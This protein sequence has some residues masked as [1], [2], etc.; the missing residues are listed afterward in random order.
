MRDERGRVAQMN[1]AMNMAK[2]GA[3]AAEV[4]SKVEKNM[5]EVQEKNSQ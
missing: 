3:D 1:M 4:G 2:Q 5:A